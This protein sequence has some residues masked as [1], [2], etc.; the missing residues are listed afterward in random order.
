MLLK[1]TLTLVHLEVDLVELLLLLVDCRLKTHDLLV[2]VVVFLKQLSKLILKSLGLL[3]N[4]QALLALGYILMLELG[5][6][7]L[8]LDVRF[9]LLLRVRRP[10]YSV[11]LPFLAK[12]RVL[13]FEELDVT[14]GAV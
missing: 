9:K 12:F 1:Q 3:V 7:L 14:H 10:I 6:L 4:L 5:H 2:K 11:Y 8:Q 13:L